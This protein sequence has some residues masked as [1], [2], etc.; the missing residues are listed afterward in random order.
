MQTLRSQFTNY[1]VNKF[2]INVSP[3]CTYCK[4]EH[5][6]ITHLYF[7]CPV[8]QTFWQSLR[9]WLKEY[10]VELRIDIFSVLFGILTERED[11]IQ[12]KLLLWGKGFIWKNKH[13]TNLLLNSAFL[14]FLKN[15]L[16]DWKNIREYLGETDSVTL[17]TQILTNIS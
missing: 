7:L 15:K 8:I 9:D 3:L 11:S 10:S 17:W 6:T 13:K 16:N 14:T 2:N 4:L 5:E 12:N 1:R